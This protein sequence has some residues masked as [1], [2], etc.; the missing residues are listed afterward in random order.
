MLWTGR[1]L[2]QARVHVDMSLKY[3]EDTVIPG[4]PTDP[5]EDEMS[6]KAFY[7]GVTKESLSQRHASSLTTLLK[8]DSVPLK[9]RHHRLNDPRHVAALKNSHDSLDNFHCDQIMPI[10]IGSNRGL[11]QIL[12]DHYVAKQQLQEQ[13]TSYTVFNVDVDIYQRI[14]KVILLQSGYP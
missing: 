13:C 3:Q 4:T 7:M 9:P 14:M 10:N 1:A 6:V 8:L 5:F 11:L 12:R 2:R